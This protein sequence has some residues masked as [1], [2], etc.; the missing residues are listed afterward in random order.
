M[1]LVDP[2]P[3]NERPIRVFLVDDNRDFLS[4]MQRFLSTA[5][6]IDIA[7]C[8]FSGREAL[9][10]VARCTPDL[11]ILDLVMPGMSG[12]EVTRRLKASPK[13]P[14]ILLLSLHE[15]YVYNTAALRAGADGF[16][17]KSEMGEQMLP[18]IHRL[19][20]RVL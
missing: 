15:H 13:A 7:G 17:A 3:R 11:V 2:P 20:A 12:L 10:S 19:F 6:R 16:L 5:P 8:A 18:L 1:L 4:A 14:H 9:I